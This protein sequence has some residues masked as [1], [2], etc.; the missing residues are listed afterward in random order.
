MCGLPKRVRQEAWRDIRLGLA[1]AP[2]EV[3]PSYVARLDSYPAVVGQLFSAACKHGLSSRTAVTAIADGGN[4][5]REELQAQFAGCRFVLD[6]PHAK[7]HLYETA[8]AMGLH[9]EAR[10]TWVQRQI[11]RLDEGN[12][13]PLLDELRRHKGR[14]KKRVNQLRA[15]F[16]RFTAL[17]SAL[18]RRG[19]P[20][21]GWVT[22]PV[23]LCVRRSPAPCA[24][25]PRPRTA[26]TVAV[27]R[28][29]AATWPS[30]Q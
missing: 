1:R 15:H 19:D 22:G 29:C 27:A 23:Q 12:V 30:R 10:E 25:R 13:E 20:Q 26:A 14:G 8:E 2:E 11:T 17:P 28:G 4:G 9:A 7:H 16:I 21:G 18:Q 24:A 6:R 3:T 5:I